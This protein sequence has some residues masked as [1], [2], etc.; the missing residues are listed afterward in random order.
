MDYRLVRE[1]HLTASDDDKPRLIDEAPTR[2]QADRKR[3]MWENRM[4]MLGHEVHLTIGPVGSD[5]LD[6]GPHT[7]KVPSVW[8]VFCPAE[9][10][11]SALRGDE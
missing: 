11:G 2:P 7:R 4:A 1:T 3:V 5:M 8:G 9:Y 10:I 6:E